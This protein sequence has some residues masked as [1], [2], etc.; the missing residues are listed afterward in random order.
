MRKAQDG[1]KV[2]IHYTG[3]L[4]DGSVFDTSDDQDPFEF[5]IG[6]GTVIPGFEQMIV[7][8]EVGETKTETI[9]CQEAY[10]F[11]RD[12][13]IGE[14]ERSQIPSDIH[15]EVGMN[16]EAVAQDGSRTRFKIIEMNN[17]TV[18][19]DANHPLAGE[20]LIFEI[21]LLDIK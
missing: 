16:L 19:L 12:E 6:S 18:T 9:P 5:T 17:E 1:D 21:R 20:D 11:R 4:K 13:L 14:I 2:L 10:G 7:G 8:M 15:P 3:Q